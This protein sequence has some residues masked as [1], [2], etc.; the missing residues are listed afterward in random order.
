MA[1]Y[2]CRLDHNRR[3]RHHLHECGFRDVCI[4]TLFDH[5]HVIACYHIAMDRRKYTNHILRRRYIK[6][7]QSASCHTGLLHR[8]DSRLPT[9]IQLDGYITAT[10]VYC[11]RASTSMGIGCHLPCSTCLLHL[12]WIIHY[13]KRLGT[14]VFR[15]TPTQTKTADTIS[16]LSVIYS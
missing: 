1:H 12:H 13:A 4:L 10:Y 2:H 14:F 11:K 15:S 7:T 8:Q 3:S 9:R 6:L 16:P 5:L